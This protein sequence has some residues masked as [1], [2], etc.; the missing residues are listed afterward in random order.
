MESSESRS[1]SSGISSQD[2]Q[3]WICSNGLSSDQELKKSS[4]ESAHVSPK[5]SGTAQQLDRGK[6]GGKLPIHQRGGAI[7]D[8]C[9]ELAQKISDHAFCS[10]GKPVA[11]M[12]EQ[13]DCIF[14]LKL[15]LFL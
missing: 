15:Y 2:T 10:T 14:H 6:K 5:V 3:R 4:L 11:Q 1:S 9:G 7:A 13:L 12:N 8:W